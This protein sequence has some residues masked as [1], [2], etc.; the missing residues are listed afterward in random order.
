MILTGWK[1]YVQYSFGVPF[2]F[3]NR[4]KRIIIPYFNIITREALAC[5]YLILK[6]RALNLSYLTSSVF[7]KHTWLYIYI[8]F[9]KFP[10]ISP[11]TSVENMPLGL[12][13]GNS[14]NCCFMSLN[15]KSRFHGTN[16][17]NNQFVI[18][19]PSSKGITVKGTLF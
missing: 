7:T 15:V 10:V 3:G 5:Y 1:T 2:K 19:T 16:I 8:P 14:S 18:V 13:P 17:I 6:R 12:I 4:V 11:T 9:L